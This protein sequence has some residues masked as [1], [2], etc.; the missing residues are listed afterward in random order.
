VSIDAARQLDRHDSCKADKTGVSI[1]PTQAAP[2]GLVLRPQ[3]PQK[4]KISDLWPG[5]KCGPLLLAPTS[6]CLIMLLGG[7]YF[8]IETSIKK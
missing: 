6:S 2:L 7:H 8:I 3:N 5:A 1:L 4:P